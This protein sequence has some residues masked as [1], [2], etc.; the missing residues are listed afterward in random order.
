MMQKSEFLKMRDCSEF[1]QMGSHIYVVCTCVYIC[2]YVCVYVC[3]YDVY[4]HMCI[5][6]ANYWNVNTHTNNPHIG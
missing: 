2:V 6:I 5:A 3:T 4:I 1:L